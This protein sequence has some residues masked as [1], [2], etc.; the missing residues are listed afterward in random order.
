[1]GRTTTEGVDAATLEASMQ[2]MVPSAAKSVAFRQLP[3]VPEGLVNDANGKPPISI[4]LF[5]QYI[6]PPWTAAQHRRALAST[7]AIGKEH[8]ITGRGRCA[9][10]GL[11]MTAT[12]TAE[13][14]RAFAKALRA[15]NP[16]FEETDFKIT[17]GLDWSKRFK[18]M[19]IQKKQD[20]VAYGLPVEKAP[21]LKDNQ[22]KHLEADEYHKMMAEPNT[23][24]I[25]VRNRYETEIGHFQ[26]PAGGAEFIDPKVRNSHELPKWLATPETK[27]KLQGKKVMM[28]CT[29][30]IRCER[31]SALLSQMKQ[32]EPDFK[33]EGEFMVR[34]GVER[35][36]KTFPQGGFWKGK[37]FLFDK[38]SEQIPEHKT[39]EALAAD[40][41][42]CCCVCKVPCAEY[43]GGFKCGE[44]ACQVP[45]IV[46]AS[47]RAQLGDGRG[48]KGPGDIESG[49]ISIATL[50]CP[51]CKEGFF[52]RDLAA[53]DLDTA[54]KKTKNIRGNSGVSGCRRPALQTC[55]ACRQAAFPATFRWQ[56]SFRGG[57]SYRKRGVG[58]G[59]ALHPLDHRPDNRNMV[60]VY[61]CADGVAGRRETRRATGPGGR[62]HPNRKATRASNLFAIK[63]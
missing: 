55:Q 37:N 59:R 47:C 20:L 15:W 54:A 21:L 29:G 43:R 60:W 31:F 41:E 4:M 25:D 11:N 33:T 46:C 42:S 32:E 44:V 49:S 27:E 63:Q 26:P 38:R 56:P 39:V 36:M 45:V 51:L 3:R 57:C 34:G 53:P 28:Y 22:T 35:Y 52:L 13:D 2:G 5:Y 17:D 40:V 58:P 12:G 24:I 6:E 30:G 50:R 62:R 19:S 14:V 7:L 8:N 18:I 1:M 61:V 23:V 9:T 48:P 10:E 16:V